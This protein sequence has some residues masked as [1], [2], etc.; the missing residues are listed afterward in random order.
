MRSRPG[1][2][3]PG[4]CPGEPIQKLAPDGT[5]RDA[6]RAAR[7]AT[8]LSASASIQRG[9]ARRRGGWP[10]LRPRGDDGNIEQMGHHSCRAAVG[11]DE[12]RREDGGPDR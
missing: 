12:L 8:V 4:A 1:G 5:A 3:P 9:S 10:R 11:S 7:Q 6:N 2:L